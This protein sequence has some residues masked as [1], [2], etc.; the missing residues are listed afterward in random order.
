MRNALKQLGTHGK[1][2]LLVNSEMFYPNPDPG[3]IWAG[4]HSGAFHLGRW[5]ACVCVGGGGIVELLLT[6]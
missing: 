1:L 5:G 2:V 4:H 6:T 3:T